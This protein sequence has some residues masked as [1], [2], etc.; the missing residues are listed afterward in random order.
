[1]LLA[2]DDHDAAGVQRSTTRYVVT[3]GADCEL[4]AAGARGLVATLIKALAITDELDPYDDDW[5]IR[6]KRGSE[7]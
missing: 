5:L 6:H 3:I 1:M 7:R 2:T 4:D